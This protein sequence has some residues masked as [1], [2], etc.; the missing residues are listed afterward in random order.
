MHQKPASIFYTKKVPTL[1][2]SVEVGTPVARGVVVVVVVVR[3]SAQLML[4][5]FAVS[6]SNKTKNEL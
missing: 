1:G 4:F 6:V 5:A 2:G 3:S